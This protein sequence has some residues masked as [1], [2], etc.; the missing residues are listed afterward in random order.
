MVLTQ[1]ISERNFSLAQQSLYDPVVSFAL[2]NEIVCKTLNRLDNIIK[3]SCKGLNKGL[4]DCG[5]SAPQTTSRPIFLPVLKRFNSTSSHISVAFPPRFRL[6]LFYFFI[7][8]VCL[9]FQKLSGFICKERDRDCGKEISLQV[10]LIFEF[11]WMYWK[12][13]VQLHFVT[14]LCKTNILTATSARESN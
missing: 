2:K 9:Y 5:V 3:S 8:S 4:F 10:F 1:N 14:T 6:I 7:F 11:V 12:R 13:V